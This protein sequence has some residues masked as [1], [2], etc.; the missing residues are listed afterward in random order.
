V[1]PG[2]GDEGTAHRSVTALAFPF[3]QFMAGAL[4]IVAETALGAYGG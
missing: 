3:V 4:V 1:V 2:H